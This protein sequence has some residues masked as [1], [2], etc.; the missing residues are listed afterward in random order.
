MQ[1]DYAKFKGANLK[2]EF[3]SEN[4]WSNL[5]QARCSVRQPDP[6]IGDKR[7]REGGMMWHMP[8]E[9]GKRRRAGRT[10]SW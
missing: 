10:R 4:L 9:Q 3:D 8:G 1:H 6:R 5:T 7:C 2:S